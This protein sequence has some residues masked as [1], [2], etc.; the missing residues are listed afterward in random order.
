MGLQATVDCNPQSDS[1]AISSA[2]CW[3]WPASER[4]VSAGGGARRLRTQVKSW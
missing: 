2:H 3:H 4:S 1:L